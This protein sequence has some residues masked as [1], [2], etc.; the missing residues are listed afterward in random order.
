MSITS[1]IVYSVKIR[2]STFMI[3]G[4]TIFIVLLFIYALDNTFEVVNICLILNCLGDSTNNTILRSP[5][6]FIA[7]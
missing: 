6:A 5:L 4:L 3:V 7:K 2:P 1:L